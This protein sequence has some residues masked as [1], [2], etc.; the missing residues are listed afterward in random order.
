MLEI[1]G[2]EF[3]PAL[4]SMHPKE[5]TTMTSPVPGSETVFTGGNARSHGTVSLFPRDGRLEWVEFA[6]TDDL[7][8]LEVPELPQTTVRFVLEAR[9]Q[10]KAGRVQA[11]RRSNR[12]IAAIGLTGDKAE[13]F[14]VTGYS[15]ASD[16]DV[17]TMLAERLLPL[18]M[19]LWE[20]YAAEDLGI[21]DGV[22][23]GPKTS[24]HT[25][26]DFA[27]HLVGQ[28]VISAVRC[29]PGPF[30][31]HFKWSLSRTARIEQGI[32]TTNP[33]EQARTF[34]PVTPHRGVLTI[35]RLEH[36]SFEA[37]VTI[38]LTAYARS[39]GLDLRFSDE[40]LGLEKFFVQRQDG[41]H[42]W[43]NAVIRSEVLEKHTGCR[44]T[45]GDWVFSRR[46]LRAA[47]SP[48]RASFFTMPSRSSGTTSSWT[49]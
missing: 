44:L 12:V 20:L 25:D 47:R 34:Q 13:S 7:R 31:A 22:L 27:I 24:L 29:P 45:T 33:V 4:T 6:V 5:I 10:S 2:A 26:G 17:R 11:L 49:F 43:K 38:P 36:E 16:D 19:R 14:G 39:R 30:C 40:V 18:G 8:A 32:E 1:S 3:S 42:S 46:R 21:V 9:K 28:D 23:L 37:R 15:D 35:R 48:M 41:W